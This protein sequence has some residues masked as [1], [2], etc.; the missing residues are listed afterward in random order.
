MIR[1]VPDVEQGNCI[2]FTWLRDQYLLFTG[3]CRGQ[4]RAEPKIHCSAA[5]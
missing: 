1:F 3:L 5:L 4:L 2:Y